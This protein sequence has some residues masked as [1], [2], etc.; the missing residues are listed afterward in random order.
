MLAEERNR[1]KTSLRQVYVMGWGSCECELFL[2]SSAWVGNMFARQKIPE[3]PRAR[4]NTPPKPLTPNH[5]LRTA[6]STSEKEVTSLR[7]C[8]FLVSKVI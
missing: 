1:S 7:F 3:E 5:G 8:T 6:P 2:F 4:E